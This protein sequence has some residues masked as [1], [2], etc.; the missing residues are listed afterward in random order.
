MKSSLKKILIGMLACVA[1]LLLIWLGAHLFTANSQ[2]AR[3]IAWFQSDIQDYKRFPMRIVANAAPRFDFRQPTVE[4]QARYAPA[5]NLIT[6]QKNGRSVTKDFEAFLEGTDTV[7]FLAIKDDALLYENYFNGYNHDST[8]TSF[9]TAKSFVSALVGIAIAE[10]YIDSVEDPITQYVPELLEKDPRYRNITLRHLLSMSS[11]INYDEHGLPWS[12]DAATYYAPDMRAL[13]ISSPIE[14]EPG[15]EFHYN[16]FHPLLLGL[17]LERTTGRPVAQYLEEKIWKP[18]GMEAPGSWSLDSQ[19]S[20]F[21]KMES[22]INGRAIDF[23]KF[24]RLFLNQGNWNGAQLIPADWVDEST[25]RDTTT[26]PV[27]NY[28]YLWWVNADV[29]G[30]H[31]FLAAGKH[32]QYIY[33]VPEQDLILVRFGKTDPL[34]KWRDIFAALAERLATQTPTD[35]AVP[36]IPT[37]PPAATA[38]VTPVGGASDMDA[39]AEQLIQVAEQ[40]DLVPVRQ[41]LAQGADVGFQDTRGRT[42]LIAAAY[43]NH[44]AVADLLIRAGAD[45]NVQDDTQQSA[46]LIATSE[47]YLDLLRLTLQAGADVH[48]T[49]SYNGTGLIRAA[50]RGHVEIIQELLKTDIK[51]DHINRLG[52][53]A[54]LEAIILGDGGAR[55]VE[56]VRLLVEAGVDVNLADGNG[57]APL[58]HAQQRGFGQIVEILQQAG[59]R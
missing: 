22:G 40:G 27:E 31:H 19:R 55:Y 15:Q 58:A 1:A 4:E 51:V 37:S 10:G 7:A 57:V 3:A 59:A 21:E 42:A 17:V 12:D 48:R 14:G 6:Y 30:E 46:Y 29:T 38:S 43:R 24:G 39:L 41:L 53:T 28:Q 11:G 36:T 47:G 56:V 25:R 32:G 23:A 45:V 13:A 2:W 54:L 16:N 44:L 52:W 49:D 9:S 33:I 34:G 26:D 50:D 5:F 35:A 20:G 18:L 8:V